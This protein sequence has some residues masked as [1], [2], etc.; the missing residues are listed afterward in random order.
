MDEIAHGK[1]K[2]P[3]T[4]LVAGPTGAGKTVLIRRLL[5]HFKPLI[6]NLNTPLLKVLWCHGQW[7]NLYSVPIPNVEVTY[8]EGLPTEED[9]QGAHLIILDD[10]MSE[11][12]KDKT[13]LNLFTKG[14]HHN[15]QSVIFISQNLFHKGPIIRDLSLNSHY[16]ILLKNPRDQSQVA[17]LARQV[18][19][20]NS[21]YFIEAYQ[22]A[23]SE[24]YGYLLV[25][26]RQDTPQRLRLRTKL[27]PEEYPDGKLAI[28]YFVPK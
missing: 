10:L 2:H 22:Q 19:P 1:F 8:M 7:Q 18:S 14:S 3:F 15:N 27:T 23:T 17:A 5:K 20:S 9:T 26:N 24:P 28:T 16:L 4:A 6:S 25:D 13:V 11:L 12:S 21:R